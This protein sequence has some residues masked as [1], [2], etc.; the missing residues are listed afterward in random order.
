VQIVGKIKF[1]AAVAGCLA[2]TGL[3]APAAS[4]D[5]AAPAN[6]VAAK[7]PVYKPGKSAFPVIGA[8][9]PVI[10]VNLWAKENYTAAQTEAYGT[11]MLAYIKNVLHAGAVDIVWNFSAPSYASNRVIWTPSTLAVQNVGILTRIAQQDHLLVEYRPMMFVLNVAN[12]WEGKISPSS[13][14][15]WFAAYYHA[16]IPYLHMAERYHVNEYVAGTEMDGVSRSPLWNSFLI[17]CAKIYK[18]VLSYADHQY[19]YFPHKRFQSPP[20]GLIGLDDYEPLA[21]PPSASLAQVVAA[22]ERYFSTVPAALLRRTALDETGIQARAGAYQA[23]SFMYIPGTLDTEVQVNWYTAACMA[24][25]KFRLRAV[26]IWKAD[27]AD[28]PAHPASSLSTFEGKP[29]A[30][31]IGRCATILKGSIR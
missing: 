1:A 12:N 3:L 25:R 9:G 31:A 22:Y 18:G 21:L 27:L 23:P 14:A 26:F 10:G 24:M 16:M 2:A 20:V 17:K 11:R 5:S 7:P 6:R 30:Q 29:G 4:A 28:N 15:R 19:L 8:S 13:D